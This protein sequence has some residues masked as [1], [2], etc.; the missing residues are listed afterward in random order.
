[1]NKLHFVVVKL[2]S[3]KLVWQASLLCFAAAIAAQAQTFQTVAAFDG[4][5]GSDPVSFSTPALILGSDGNFYGTT[6]SGG[7]NKSGT[8]F[9]VSPAGALSALYSFCSQPNCADGSYPDAGLVQGDDGNFYGTTEYGGANSSTTGIGGGTFFKITPEGV[10]T[11]LYSFCSLSGCADGVAPSWLVKGVNGDFYGSSYVAANRS[12]NIFQITP[13]GALTILYTFCGPDCTGGSDPSSLVQ[14]SDGNL[15][16]TT[17]WGGNS[18]S[19][20]GNYGCGTFF[21]LTLSGTLT[22]LYDFCS[23]ANCADGVGPGALVEGSDGDFYGMTGGGGTAA[24]PDGTAFRITAGGTLTTLSSFSCPSDLACTGNGSSALMQGSD[25]N[26]YGTDVYGGGGI[27][28]PVCEYNG[29]GTFFQL[30]P[31]GTLTTLYVFCSHGSDTNGCT[32]GAFPASM[33]VE[34]S[35]GTFYGTTT[36]GGGAGCDSSG[37]GTVFSWSPNVSVAP[38]FTPSSL[39]FGNEAIDTTSKEKAVTIKNASTGTL[40]F[41]SF[42]VGAPFAISLNKCGTTLDAGKTCQVSVTFD[43]S[44]LGGANGTFSVVDN[45]PGS[46]QTVP[47]SGTGELQAALKPA[48]V[49]FGTHKVGTT[50]GVW[51]ITLENNLPTTLTGITYSTTGPFAVSSTTCATTLASNKDCTFSVTFTPTTTGVATGTLSVSDSAN[52]SPQ[53]VSLSGTGD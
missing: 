37:C 52:N 51:S 11:T 45:A 42:S 46:P 4:S 10:L 7:S 39:A 3:W 18:D 41:S 38:T 2:H 34:P 25:G 20:C 23:L 19:K 48:S 24:S 9:E 35:N 12:N 27:V 22:T 29:C 47:L 13:S 53:T 44:T 15:Y 8:V 33:V 36:E 49:N 6:N 31:S 28:K 40:A 50:S 17:D 30:T 32:D 21:R 26:F 1:V 14:G 43:P 5:D 16:G